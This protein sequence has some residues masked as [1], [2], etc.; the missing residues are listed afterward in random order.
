[1]LKAQTLS[2]VIP[3][4][5]EEDHID[6]CLDTIAN[7]TV[8]PDEVIVVDNNC[9]DNTI[10]L[11]KRYSFVKVVHE[12]KQGITHARNAG[13]DAAKSDIIG[14]IDADTRLPINWVEHAKQYINTHPQELLTGGSYMY[15][16]VYPRLA[17]WVQGQLAFRANFFILGH[18]IAWGSNMAFRKE[19][20]Q[21][22]R[23]KLH[24]DPRIHEDMDLG[25]HLHELG[26]KIT[27]QPDWKV[28]IESRLLSDKRRTRK[29]HMDYLKMWPHTLE[30]HRLKRAWVGWLGVYLVYF[31]YVPFWLLHKFG[32][33][34][35]LLKPVENS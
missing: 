25:M 27:Y 14:R 35:R 24:N 6:A 15:D 4:Y 3:V 10:R 20:W 17:G 29:Q 7:Q 34:M 16:L 13:F 5:N 19:L 23:N 18:Y 12:T 11:A 33:V 8:L 30:K 2:I 9:T 22:V 31:S 32:M 21:R 1:M 26:Y 28:G